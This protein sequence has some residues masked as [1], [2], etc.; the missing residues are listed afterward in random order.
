MSESVAV[1]GL[2]TLFEQIQGLFQSWLFQR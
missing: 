1:H 2:Q